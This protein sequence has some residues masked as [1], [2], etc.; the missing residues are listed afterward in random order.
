MILDRFK[1][2]HSAYVALRKCQEVDDSSGHNLSARLLS[3]FEALFSPTAAP[4]HP[5]LGAEDE[6]V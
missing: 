2:A 4:G 3:E 1:A 5:T 6:R